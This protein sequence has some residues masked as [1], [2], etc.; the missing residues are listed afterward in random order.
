MS[1]NQDLFQQAQLAE[2]AYAILWNSDTNSAIT[3]TEIVKVA[4]RNEGMSLA[5]ATDFV[6]HWQVV[7]HLR[8]TTDG[9]SA[10][11]KWGLPSN[12]WM[13]PAS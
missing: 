4:L 5:Q 7:D 3:D 9:F 6:A 13:T 11:N 12:L 1:M 8:N 2:A 10:Q